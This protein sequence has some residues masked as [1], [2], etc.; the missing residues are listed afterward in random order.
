MTG[1]ARAIPV[2]VRQAL[3]NE[4]DAVAGILLEAARW[5]EQSGRPMWR[6]DELSSSRIAADV[7]AGLFFLAECGGEAA[8]T[9]KFQLEDL[10]FWPDVTQEQSAFVHRL[11]VRRP[12]AGKGVS[13]AM[14]R[15]AALR[16][17][18]L[19]RSFLRLDCEAARP[20]LREIYERLGFR[21]HSDR[22]V[23]P[24][25]VARYELKV[26]RQ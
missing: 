12:F 23:G 22:R 13:S 16:A 15:W 1:P 25:F 26:P 10:E 18:S 4:A 20:R 2:L 9:L 6:D 5:L 17:G 24:Y 3:T 19:G 7:D 8:G 14:L 21:H 11:A